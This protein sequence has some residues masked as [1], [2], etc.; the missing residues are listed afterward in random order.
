M[1][2]ISKMAD[3]QNK[4]RYKFENIFVTTDLISMKF[5]QK[6]KHI[7]SYDLSPK[8]KNTIG[9]VVMATYAETIF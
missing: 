9:I 7:Y 4:Y 1:V 3:I 2:T 6:I 8:K 5:S